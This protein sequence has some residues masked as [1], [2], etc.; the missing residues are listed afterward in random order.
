MLHSTGTMGKIG[1][2]LMLLAVVI[3]TV[4]NIINAYNVWQFNR[5]A[6]KHD[7]RKVDLHWN[8]K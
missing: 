5:T 4:D 3:W 6:S 7:P 2:G 1:I 8:W